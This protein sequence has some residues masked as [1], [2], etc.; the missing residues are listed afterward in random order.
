MK[1]KA[2]AEDELLYD[3][4]AIA[5]EIAVNAMDAVDEALEGADIDL[6]AKKIIWNDGSRLTIEESAQRISMQSG[7]DL[8]AITNHII[9]WLTMD[10]V[11]TGLT[12]KQMDS[13]E[14]KVDEWVESYDIGF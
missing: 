12:Q 11:P 5:T 1:N 8:I 2:R 9:N 3:N 4:E 13:F 10:F 7:E 6:Q 14:D